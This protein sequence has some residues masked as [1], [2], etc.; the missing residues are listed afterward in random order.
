MGPV[1]IRVDRRKLILE[2][3]GHETLGR[4]V[5]AF[6]RLCVG[7]DIEDGCVAFHGTAVDLDAV[8]DVPDAPHPCL[9]MLEGHPPDDPMDFISFFQQELR[10][11]AP[12]LSRDPGDERFFHCL[13]PLGFRRDPGH[14]SIGPFAP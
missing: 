13:S 12:V 9:G 6:I 5:I 3:I 8:Q 1:E 10:Q 14:S 4:Q 2:G 11:I 7:N